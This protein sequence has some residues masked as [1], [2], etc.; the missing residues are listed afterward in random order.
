MQ[1]TF[2]NVQVEE[3]AVEDCLHTAGNDSDQV[4][5]AFKVVAVDPVNDVESTVGAQREQIVAGDGFGLAGL[6]NHEQLWQDGH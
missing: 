4:E 5:E 1:H 2:C 3:V 6:A